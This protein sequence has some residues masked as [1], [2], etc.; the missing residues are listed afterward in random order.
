ML[1]GERSGDKNKELHPSVCRNG[2][3]ENQQLGGM[4]KV[5]CIGPSYLNLFHFVK[6]NS[7]PSWGWLIVTSY[8]LFA[9]KSIEQGALELHPDQ[10]K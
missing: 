5:P 10:I 2:A 8:W 6:R 3:L 7:D 9:R 4:A 1:R